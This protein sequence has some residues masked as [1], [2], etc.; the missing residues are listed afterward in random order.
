MPNSS[1]PRPAVDPEISAE[2]LRVRIAEA[3]ASGTP[4]RIVGGGSKAFYG[5]PWEGN[6]LA[7]TGH[8]GIVGYE[9]GELV[10][11]VR[12]GTPLAEIEAHLAAHRQ[13][14]AWE[15]P[16]FAPQAT[17]GGAIATGLSGPRRPYA[18]A[19]R[20]YVLGLRCITGRGEIQAF[21]GRV[22]KNV[23]GFDVSRLMVGALGTLGLILDVS[24]KLLPAPETEVTVRFADTTADA[25]ARMNRLA[26]HPALSATCHYDGRTYARFSG[27]RD[28]VRAAVK[29]SAG[30]VSG[31]DEGLWER[32]REQTHPFFGDDGQVLWRMSL[33]STAPP[34][35]LPGEWLIEWGGAQRWLKTP[36]TAAE[37]RQSVEQ[38]G[39]HATAFRGHRGKVPV[40]HPLPPELARIHARLKTSFD[41]AGIFNRGHFFPG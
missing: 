28:G 3:A 35:P 37:V 29:A 17:I 24:V 34:L 27:T 16:R 4:V 13:M 9:P 19:A 23:A 39:G 21:G 11:T 36:A 7:T 14:L 40:F 8:T 12:A 32:L 22:I 1:I 5:N 2:T 20:D 38:Y 15:P 6:E 30:E 18:G 41:P 26:M 10:M 33:A 25:I 31:E